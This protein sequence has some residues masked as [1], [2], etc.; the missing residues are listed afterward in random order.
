MSPDTL[1]S[2]PIT[3]GPAFVR[4]TKYEVANG[5]QTPNLGERK[6]VGHMED[7]SMRSFAA[8]VLAVNESLMSV[9]KIARA[10]HRVNFDDYGSSIEDKSS[11]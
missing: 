3:S 1:V 4:G 7:G 10:G 2:V 11:G 5:V 6:F 8:Q 9:S